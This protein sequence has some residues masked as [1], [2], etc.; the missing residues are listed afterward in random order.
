MSLKVFFCIGNKSFETIQN[1]QSEPTF[2]HA[3]EISQMR[4]E[5]REDSPL[6]G[7]DRDSKMRMREASRGVDNFKVA[8]IFKSLKKHYGLCQAGE[9]KSE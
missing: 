1:M 9:L 4:H 6:R 3:S 7:N 8:F 2:D 5:S